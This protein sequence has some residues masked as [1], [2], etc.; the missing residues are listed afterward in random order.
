[1]VTNLGSCF[2]H[3]TL[4]SRPISHSR[5]V[6]AGLCARGGVWEG[7]GGMHGVYVYRFTLTFFLFF[8]IMNHG[9]MSIV[10]SLSMSASLYMDIYIHERGYIY[11]CL[12]VRVFVRTLVLLNVFF[13][14]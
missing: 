8:I 2:L 10:F 12:D 6:F 7:G 13:R 4:F 11:V 3:L 5:P 14:V 1:M 9:F